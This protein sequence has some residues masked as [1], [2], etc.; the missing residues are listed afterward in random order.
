MNAIRFYFYCM[1]CDDIV[2]PDDSGTKTRCCC[3]DSGGAY[4]RDSDNELYDF[5]LWGDAV[6]IH[7]DDELRKLSSRAQEGESPLLAPWI[8]S[9]SFKVNCW[10]VTEESEQCSVSRYE[11]EEDFDLSADEDGY[12]EPSRIDVS[13]DDSGSP[14]K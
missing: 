11:D 6:P 4:Y 10:I 3:G 1:G 13:T 14:E 8:A 2:S 12:V 9:P 7:F 5:W